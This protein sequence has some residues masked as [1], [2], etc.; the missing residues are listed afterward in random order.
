MVL[1]GVGRVFD[2]HRQ[3]LFR[4]HL[5]LTQILLCSGIKSAGQDF[6]LQMQKHCFQTKEVRCCLQLLHTHYAAAGC[7]VPWVFMMQKKIIKMRG[8]SCL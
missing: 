8:T 4:Y 6:S 3:R 5:P 1:I 7:I 2:G